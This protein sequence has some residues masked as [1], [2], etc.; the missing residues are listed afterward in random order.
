MV[1]TKVFLGFSVLVWLPYGAFCIFQPE[2]LAEVAGVGA[3]TAT[4][5]TEIRAMYGGL[6]AGIG[7]LCAFA[8]FRPSLVANVLLSLAFLTGGLAIARSIGFVLDWSS[9][10]YTFGALGFEIIN[11]LVAV[12]LARRHLK[13]NA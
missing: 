9:S 10:G 1:A 11:T 4:G 2:Y 8:F 6:Q 13:A 3:T 5:T 12:F 7:A